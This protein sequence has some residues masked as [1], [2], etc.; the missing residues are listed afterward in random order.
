MLEVGIAYG[1]SS[2]REIEPDWPSAGLDIQPK[3][4]EF[5]IVGSKGK[6]VGISSIKAGDGTT[7]STTITVTLDS[8]T[9]ATAFD[10][11]TPLRIT[12]AG[13]GY[14][15]QFVVSNK[16]DA[17]NIQYKVQSA[18][19]DPLPTIASATANVTVDT[20]TSA[21]P[22]IFNCSLRSVYGMCGLLADGDKATGFQSMVLAQFTGVGLQKDNNAFVKYNATSG[23]YEDKTAT[24]NSNLESDSRARYKPTYSNFHIKATNNSILQAVSCFAI[25][26][27]NQFTTESGGELS[28]TNSNSNFGANGF[29]SDGF[30]KDAFTRDDVG[31]IS[32]IIPPKVNNNTETGTEFLALD[33]K[34]IVG[35]AA[36]N[37]MYL[38]N[39]TNSGVAPES[40]VDGYRIGAKENDTL[41]V[42]ISKSGV[43]TSIPA[44]II[45]PSTEFTSSEVSAEKKFIV[46][47]SAVGVNSVSSN[48]FTLTGDHNFINGETIRVNSQNG[49]LPDGLLHNTVYF[50][51]TSGTGIADSD[52]I[53][54]GKT[55][56]DAL[57]DEAITVNSNGGLLDVVSRVSDKKSGDLGHPIQYDTDASHW[58]VN[59]ATGSTEDSLYNSIVG[60][61]ST[62]LGDATA[63]SF[64]N[65]KSETRSLD[66]TIYQ[67]KICSSICFLIRCTSS[68]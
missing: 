57:G 46:G 20:V 67:C 53:K 10:V 65:R 68:N 6:E 23:T 12:N 1:P 49:H 3:I 50:A 18:P 2:G 11:D 66:D 16:V 45:M 63:R 60:L 33:V 7:T 4:D 28:I 39:E 30:R 52:Q 26:Y 35:M 31:Y 34:K 41:N 48:V 61:G 29:T 13:T 9:G 32:H 64:I 43:T 24:G 14:D 21:S 58:Y 17:T 55:L 51:I 59:V 40:I 42:L 38:Y 54:I 8:A 62:S 25:G 5:R 19:D 37:K 56:N 36:T 47:N 27:A 44:R 15:G 22:Y